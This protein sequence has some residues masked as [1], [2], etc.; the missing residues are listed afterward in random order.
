MLD[1][2]GASDHGAGGL[3][4]IVHLRGAS[5]MRRYASCNNP[6]SRAGIGPLALRQDALRQ[7]LQGAQ[8]RR[9]DRPYLT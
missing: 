6:R 7:L 4:S 8:V 3:V 5:C 1:W 9:D 2:P